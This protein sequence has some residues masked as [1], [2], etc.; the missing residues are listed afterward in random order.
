MN[1]M[2]FK[3]A[4]IASK[5]YGDLS[6]ISDHTRQ[7]VGYAGGPGRSLEKKSKKFHKFSANKQK[8]IL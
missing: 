6:V 8:R 5:M 7:S 1:I 4:V 3:I 2:E